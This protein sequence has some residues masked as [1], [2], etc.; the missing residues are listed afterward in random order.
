MQMVRRL[1]IADDNRD[2][3]ESMRML[4]TLYGREVQ[5]AIDGNAAVALAKRFCPD[6]VIM[7]LNMPHLDGVEACRRI[8]SQPGWRRMVIVAVSA[9]EGAANQRAFWSAGFDAHMTK[10]VEVKRLLQLLDNIG[11]ASGGELLRSPR[12]VRT[13]W[14]S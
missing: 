9:A 4:L 11:A 3:L 12:H 5:T 6:A 7:D 2:I 13:S 14:R 8:R 10:P 1:L